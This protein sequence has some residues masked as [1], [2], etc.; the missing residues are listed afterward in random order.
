MKSPA[1]YHPLA[2][3]L[4]IRFLYF[5][6]LKLLKKLMG[7]NKSV[8]EAACGYGR[9]KQYM[10][11]SISYSGIDLNPQ[12]IVFGQKRGLNISIGNALEPQNFQKADVVLLADILHH[13]PVHHMKT[14]FQNA[15]QTATEKIV[16]IEPSFV[17]L[18]SK[19][20]ILSKA[21]SKF[22]ISMDHDGFNQINRWLSR[23]EYNQLFQNLKEDNNIKKMKITRHR[24]HD[25]VEMF[26]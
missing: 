13:L 5:D 18:A 20:N 17:T 16:I 25:F 4:A 9:M 14:L 26:V 19:K 21:L 15:A 8:F 11:P 24:N 7:K 2:Y 6:G 3:D 1:Y 23:K 22:M 10:D 12:F